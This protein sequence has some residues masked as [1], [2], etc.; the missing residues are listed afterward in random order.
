MCSALGEAHAQ[1]IVHRDLKPENLVVDREGQVRIMDFGI[2]HSLETDKLEA[3]VVVGTPAYMSPEQA[4]GRPL[5]GRSDIYALGLI[6]YEMFTGRQAFA[7]GTVVTQLKRRL[8]EA[9]PSPRGVEPWLP[10]FLERAILKC[11]ER[12]PER[13]YA[14]VGELERALAAREDES[15]DERVPLPAHLSQARPKDA[16][17]LLAGVAGLVAFVAGYGYSTPESLVRVRL[18]RPML[19]EKATAELTARG[20]PPP[21]APRIG[22]TSNPGPY[23]FLARTNG[24]QPARQ[25][26]PQ[27]Y[28]HLLLQARFAKAENPRDTA[29]VVTYEPDGDL[30]SV[31][32]PVIGFVPPGS[33]GLSRDDALALA[34]R[35][36]KTV[37]GLDGAK[38]SVEQEGTL[39]EGTRRGHSFR[40][41]LGD[42]GGVRAQYLVNVF[43][44]VTEVRK[45]HVLP[46]DFERRRSGRLGPV[47]F[48]AWFVPVLAVFFLRRVYGRIHG[49]E[50]LSLTLIGAVGAS[51]TVSNANSGPE[52]ALVYLFG[53]LLLA[54]MAIVAS[55]TACFLTQRPWPHVAA[56]YLAALRLRAPRVPTALAFAR[57]GALGLAILGLQELL[58]RLGTAFDL[59]WPLPNPRGPYFSAPLPALVVL[60]EVV[61]SSFAVTLFLTFVLSLARRLT[62]SPLL[63]TLLGGAAWAATSLGS[64]PIDGYNVA[65][66]FL[67]GAAYSAVLVG[68]DVLTLFALT[69]SSSVWTTGYALLS[70]FELVGNTPV[71]LLLG[72]WSLGTAAALYFGMRQLLQRGV[73][74][75]AL[76]AD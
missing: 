12:D 29:A 5:D 33:A 62:P 64:L 72:L 18:T 28:P 60:A 34:Q 43:D 68:F 59:T 25:A 76:P 53:A 58:Q 32:L 52:L 17:L 30:R 2:A 74:E 11:L 24:N 71:V 23:E 21:L 75:A 44:R 31:E 70:M 38:M 46:E 67:L 1:G 36:L 35:E 20:W 4:E 55:S 15:D 61:L 63:L 13:R 49:R 10:P 41:T 50:A 19:M 57:G 39:T 16:A 3:G 51:L 66:Q 42:P 48:I 7:G 22:A 26:L 47:L 40:W 8:Q 27:Q 6:A 54:G 69:L 14:S 45:E 73:S 37:F 56:G 9:P 65:L